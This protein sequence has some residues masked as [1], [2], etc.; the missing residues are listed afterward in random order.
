MSTEWAVHAESFFDAD[1][2][3]TDQRNRSGAVEQQLTK[4]NSEVDATTRRGVTN[5]IRGYPSDCQPIANAHKQ[6][7]EP[8]PGLGQ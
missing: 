4:R 5:R 2:L 1:M 6:W 3:A 7:R 8:R